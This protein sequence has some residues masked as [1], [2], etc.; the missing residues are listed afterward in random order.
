MPGKALPGRCN[1]CGGAT[2]RKR[3]TQCRPCY[4]AVLSAR[5]VARSTHR[6]SVSRSPEYDA[7]RAMKQRCAPHNGRYAPYYANRGIVV[8]ERWQLSFQAFLSDVGRRPTVDHSLDRI[9][10]DGN[11]EPGNVRWATWSQQMLNRRRLC[12]TGAA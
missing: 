5:M 2:N 6:E 7:W 10:N 12:K 1:R 3:N 11:Y 8:C 4:M 9:N